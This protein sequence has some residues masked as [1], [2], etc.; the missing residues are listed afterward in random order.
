MSN[1][2]HYERD[3]FGNIK[4]VLAPD[5]Q[6]THLLQQEE[7]VTIAIWNGLTGGRL[8]ELAYTKPFCMPASN[9]AE[10]QQWELLAE[11]E[12]WLWRREWLPGSLIPRKKNGNR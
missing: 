9:S 12:Q 11:G 8:I 4:R 6:A 2:Y 10:L 1:R 5:E 3:E 7:G